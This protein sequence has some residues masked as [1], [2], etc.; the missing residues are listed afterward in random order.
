MPEFDVV[1]RIRDICGE[2]SWTYY[3]L[4]KESGITYSTL[5]AMMKKGTIPSVPTLEKICGGFGISLSQFFSEDDTV[6]ALTEGEKQYLM[7]WNDLTE[8]NKAC[9]D[10]FVLFLLHQQAH[11]D[12]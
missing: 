8:E 2:Y 4:A 12:Q 9:A 7:N 3:R 10:K 5:N 11:S 6:A 1:K